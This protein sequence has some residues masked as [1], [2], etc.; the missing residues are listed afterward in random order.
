MLSR[1]ATPRLLFKAL[2]QHPK[3]YGM[4][5]SITS[6]KNQHNRFWEKVANG[7]SPGAQD[8]KKPPSW[9]LM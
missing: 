5:G 2:V 6:N 8:V 3:L 1:H 9:F 7:C 4:S